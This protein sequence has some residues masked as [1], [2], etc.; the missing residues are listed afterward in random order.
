MNVP[1]DRPD[2]AK[3]RVSSW[4]CS[5]GYSSPLEVLLA[6]SIPFVVQTHFLISF[7]K[8]CIP[9][10][11]RE[12]SFNRVRHSPISP[13]IELVS[14][15]LQS[16][17]VAVRFPASIHDLATALLRDVSEDRS[18]RMDRTHLPSNPKKCCAHSNLDLL[19]TIYDNKMNTAQSSFFH[20][21]KETWSGF[22]DDL[23][24]RGLIGVQLDISDGHR[25][26]QTAV[27]TTIVGVS[28]QCARCI[29]PEQC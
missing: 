16:L 13:H 25:G 15:R 5:H 22:F 23:K 3:E 29:R 10:Q 8:S 4:K 6:P 12:T 20:S 17:L 7:K 9:H 21:I 11:S 14:Q 1:Q 24:E 26:I 18:N 19:V 27:I 2:L 28:W